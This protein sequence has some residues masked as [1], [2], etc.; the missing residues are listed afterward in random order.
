MTTHPLSATSTLSLSDLPRAALLSAVC[1]L[2]FHLLKAIYNISPFH[3][4]YSIPGPK[5]AAATYIPE[6]YFD[7]VKFGRYTT[8]IQRMH[9]KYG[10]LVRIS[11]NEIHCA[12]VAFSD[13]IYA[14]GARKRDKPSHQ[15]RG[16]V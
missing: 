13:E 4:L 15:V 10:P 12:D 16:T 1:W 11:P 5:L 3:P 9:D 8:Q 2:V 14:I 7:V 6:F